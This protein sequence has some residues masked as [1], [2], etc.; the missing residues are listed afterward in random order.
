MEYLENY[1][2]KILEKILEKLET[3][4]KMLTTRDE[5]FLNINETAEYLGISKMTL[6]S[7]TSKNVIPFYKN[8]GRRIYFKIDDLNDWIL[9]N[10]NRCYSNEDIESKALKHSLSTGKKLF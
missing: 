9:N 8:R 5:P 4:E 1:D 10:R 6:Y 3:I 7:Y 2:Q